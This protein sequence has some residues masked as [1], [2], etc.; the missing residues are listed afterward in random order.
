MMRYAYPVEISEA[1]DGVTLTF[2]DVPEVITCGATV[3][4]ALRR[5]PDAL[6][7]GLSF[8][9]ADLRSLPVASPANGRVVISVG[10]LEAAKLGLHDAMLQSGISN[11]ALANRLGLDEK[12]MQ[13]LR[14]PLHRSDIA[15]VEQALWELG[16]RINVSVEASPASPET[17]SKSATVGVLRV[18]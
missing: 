9:V 4:E 7:T 14:D 3:E 6:A 18:Q 13:R 12:A 8:Y 1:A 10:A 16:R 11:A 5:A 15:T 2:P 17:P